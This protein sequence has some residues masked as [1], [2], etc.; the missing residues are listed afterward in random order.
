MKKTPDIAI[1]VSA[2]PGPGRWAFLFLLIAAA[3]GAARAEE[4]MNGMVGL[5][6]GPDKGYSFEYDLIAQVWKSKNWMGNITGPF[7]M[8]EISTRGNR[9]GVGLV[10]GSRFEEK[11]T[12]AV[13]VDI[14]AENRWDHFSRT[15]VGAEGKLTL[16][17]LGVKVGIMNWE[18]MYW[19]AGFSY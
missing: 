2:K 6:Y 13:A 7:I 10:T 5:W 14:Y 8:E 15:D 1:P 18:K 11:G 9:I 19:Q 17:I 12:F 16:F 4:R 3:A